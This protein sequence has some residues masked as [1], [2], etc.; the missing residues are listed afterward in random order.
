MSDATPELRAAVRLNLTPGV[1]PRTAEVLCGTFGSPAAVFAAPEADLRRISGI[2]AKVIGALRQTTEQAADEELRR[3]ADAGVTVLHLGDPRY[4]PLLAEIPTAPRVLYVRGTLTPEDAAAIAMVGS[5]RCSTYGTR[6][7]GSLARSL[8]RAGLTVVSGMALGID[9]AAHRGALEAGGRTLAVTATGMNTVYPPQHRGL[10]ED[11]AARGA[12]VT[13]FP[14][15]QAPTRGLFP[16]RNRVIAGLSLGVILVEAGR[17]S[18][19]LHTIRHAVE[20]NREVFVVPGRLDDGCDGGLD[21]LR[22][23]ATL[24]RDAD[25]VLADLGGEWK[26]PQTV[27]QLR[28]TLDSGDKRESGG[29]PSPAKESPRSLTDV[30]AAVFAAVPAGETVSVDVVMESDAAERFGPGRALAA[31][32]TLEMK[33]VL[34]RLPGNRLER[35]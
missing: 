20:Q 7:A 19:A 28:L 1:G 6:T 31:L 18:G 10:A 13:E 3:A 27:P 32:T 2:G 34:R 26:R 14:M 15:G 24:I 29:S 33:R 23:G 30:E 8:A 12:I 5:R 22:D 11:I 9:G 21:A 17:K 35:A 25:D 16:Q 4:P